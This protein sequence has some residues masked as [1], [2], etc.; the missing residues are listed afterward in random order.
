VLYMDLYK[1]LR[2]ANQFM[3]RWVFL[4]L[5]II[6][7]NQCVWICLTIICMWLLC[8]NWE[9]HFDELGFCFAMHAP[10]LEVCHLLLL[11]GHLKLKVGFVLL[12]LL[13]WPIWDFICMLVND[14]AHL[15][16]NSLLCYIW[17]SCFSC[18]QF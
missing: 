17:T 9:W 1:L 2:T 11:I 16:I 6:I 13:M 8:N 10:P 4:S 5:K 7:D 15:F 18:L 12:F 14:N 3:Y